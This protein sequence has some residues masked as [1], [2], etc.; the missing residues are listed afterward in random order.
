MLKVD[1]HLVERRHHRRPLQIRRGAVFIGEDDSGNTLLR[2]PDA[3]SS[4]DGRKRRWVIYSGYAEASKV[5]ADGTAGC[6][7]PS[8]SRRRA[9]PADAPVWEKDHL[10]NLTGTIWAWRPKGSI[11]RG[12]ERA[13]ATGD[14]EPWT[15]E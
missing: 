6:T 7:T 3:A 8:T 1:L 15:P 13:E 14:Y 9:Q 5:P 4:Y 10:P 11:A 2:D 12:G